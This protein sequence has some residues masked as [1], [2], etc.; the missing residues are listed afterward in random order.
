MVISSLCLESYLIQNSLFS[1]KMNDIFP[2]NLPIM[3]LIV[4]LVSFIC[5]CLSNIFIQT[6]KDADYKW[7]DI[8]KLY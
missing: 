1:T 2:L 3:I 5:K 7:K 6:F 8:I 4:L